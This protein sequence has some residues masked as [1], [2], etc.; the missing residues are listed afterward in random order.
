[1]KKFVIQIIGVLIVT[2][3]LLLVLDFTYT[4]VY[5]NANPRTKFQYLRSLKNTKVNYVFLGSSR[6]ENG[7]DP[8]IIETYTHK[9]AVNLGY[10]AS[11]LGDVFSILQLL[12]SYAIASDTIFVQ[13]DYSFLSSGNSINLPYEMSPFIRDNTITKDYFLEYLKKHPSFYYFPFIRYCENETKIGIREVFANIIGKKTAVLEKQG[14]I[15]LAGI[16]DQRNSHRSLPVASITSNSYF[17]KIKKYGATNNVKIV[18]FCAPFCKHVKNLDYVE[19]L[20][21]K[22]PDLHDFSRVIQEDSKFV[23]CFHLNEAGATEFTKIFAE[24]LLK[25]NKK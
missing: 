7:I 23:N 11:K 4:T 24:G 5:K 15:P 8:I 13:V 18:F 3:M 22:I 20:K 25:N 16:E 14:F 19:K 2:L 12:K 10:Q 9:K 17:E 6:V 1:M 21:A